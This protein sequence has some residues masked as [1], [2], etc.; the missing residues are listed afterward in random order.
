[1]YLGKDET[2]LVIIA[3]DLTK[4]RKEKLLRVWTQDTIG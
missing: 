2:F 3:N 4:V 1:V